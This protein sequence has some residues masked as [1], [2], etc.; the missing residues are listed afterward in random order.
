M[1][2]GGG[3]AAARSLRAS[4][5]NVRRAP[6]DV[7]REAASLPNRPVAIRPENRFWLTVATDKSV[8]HENFFVAKTCDSESAHAAFRRRRRLAHD[9]LAQIPLPRDLRKCLRH[10]RFLHS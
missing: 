5:S 9:A 3:T 7:D 2:Q 1:W 6:P 8:K 4:A 10:S